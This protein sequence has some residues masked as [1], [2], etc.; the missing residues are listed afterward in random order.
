MS[1]TGSHG[2]LPENL[3]VSEDMDEDAL[4]ASHRP[5]CSFA[6]WRIF[7][8]ILIGTPYGLICCPRLQFARDDSGLDPDSDLAPDLKALLTL[9]TRHA[10]FAVARLF[11]DPLFYSL[12]HDVDYDDED[13][14]VEDE[15]GLY[16]LARC[17]RQITGLRGDDDSS[18]L[19]PSGVAFIQDQF[20]AADLPV[21]TAATIAAWTE[22]MRPAP[23]PI[24]ASLPPLTSMHG[25]SRDRLVLVSH[26]SDYNSLGAIVSRPFGTAVTTHG[27]QIEELD[28]AAMEII[29]SVK[30]PPKTA[31]HIRPSTANPAW[32]GRAE[33]GAGRDLMRRALFVPESGNMPDPWVVDPILGKM[34][35]ES[36][37]IEY[38]RRIVHAPGTV[39]AVEATSRGVMLVRSLGPTRGAVIEVCAYDGRNLGP[40]LPA[41]EDDETD[42]PFEH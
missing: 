1:A 28:V 36:R 29:A 5:C 7:G 42:V 38:V 18:D 3:T 35:Q 16:A 12:P 19:S 41:E 21:P 23:L 39:I 37:E 40:G 24:R 26:D 22:H 6:S 15:E 20:R 34:E 4:I 30:L 11:Y 17:V 13:D 31:Y 25:A 2:V 9:V 10:L 8:R 27:P 33:S 32:W 14:V